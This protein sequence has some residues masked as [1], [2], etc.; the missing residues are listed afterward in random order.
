VQG[1]I[2]IKAIHWSYTPQ[3]AM[4]HFAEVDRWCGVPKEIESAVLTRC[5]EWIASRWCAKQLLKAHRIDALLASDPVHGFPVLLD[6]LEQK[7]LPLSISWAHS[8]TQVAVALSA[9]SVGIDTEPL[10]RKV[11]NVLPR[12]SETLEWQS[13]EKK[14]KER[15]VSYSP[16]LAVWCAK[17]AAAKASGLGMKWGLKNFHLSTGE[18]GLWE[19]KLDRLGPKA[20]PDLVVTVFPQKGQLV[21]I[22]ANRA[23]LLEGVTWL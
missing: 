8:G 14:M 7:P 12:I 2:G 20:T 9:F 17:E 6:S 22:A 4:Q 19:V 23:H 21:A 11:E 18:N 13:I 10:D 16:A 15:M 5:S 3:E 1:I